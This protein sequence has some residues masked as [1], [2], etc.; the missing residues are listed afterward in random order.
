[1]NNHYGTGCC[2]AQ[3]YSKNESS[4]HEIVKEGKEICASFAVT[5]QMQKLLLQCVI[6]ANVRWKKA[7]NL[8][9][10]N[11]NRKHA[12]V[13][14]NMFAPKSTELIQSMRSTERF[15]NFWRGDVCQ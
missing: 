12:P 8:W 14:S 4:V 15:K 11:I 1:V 5:P 7:L 2:V 9:V 10:E 6:N 13:D 3:I